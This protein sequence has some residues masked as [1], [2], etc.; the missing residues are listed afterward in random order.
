MK[1]GKCPKCGS[2]ELYSNRDK[3]K[4]GYHSIIDFTALKN[5]LSETIVCGTCGFTEDF[6]YSES[7]DKIKS[8]WTK[9]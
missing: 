3:I 4:K 6:V 5:I 7:L 2:I 1:S 9:L 8:K